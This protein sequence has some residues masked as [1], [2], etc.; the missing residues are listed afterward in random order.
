MSF[1][2]G[3]KRAYNWFISLVAAA[4]MVLY[5]YDASVFNSVQGSDNWMAYFN[6][7]NAATIGSIN[8]AYT[9]GAIFGGFFVGGPVADYLGRKV[10]M[11]TGCVLVI[12]ATFMQTFAPRHSLACFLAGR[13]I[14][15]I[16]QG[17]ALTAGP[18]YIGEL[19]PPEIRGKIMTFWQMFYSVGS[20]ICF[21]I[22]YACT[23][24]VERLGEWD[25]K[26]VVIFQLLVPILIVAL[27][28][29]M[30]G[31]PRWFI[32][33]GNNIE[34]ARSALRRV[35]ESEEE[36][37]DEILQIREAIEYEK[38]AISGNYSALWK[39]KSLR[40]RML[41]AL[42]INAGQQLTGQGSLNSYSTKIYKKVF[43]SDS[44]IALINALNATF[45]I[46]FTLNAVWIVDRFGRKFLLIVGGIGMGI[47]MIIVSAVETETPNLA[48][49][50]KSMPVG[51]STV[52][53][54]FLF[55]F[56]YKPSWGAT[57]WIWTSE[58]FSMN[59]R[60][61]AVGMASQ[62]Q[63]VANTIFQQFFPIFL[64]NDG[65]YAFYMFAGINF[66]L[67]VFV[68]FFI[69]ETKQVPL[70]EIDALFGGANHVVQGEEVLAHQKGMQI[71]SEVREVN[72]KPDAVTIENV[73]TR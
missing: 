41:L 28:P 5:G 16:G 62:T 44:Q 34:K 63:N 64:D 33:R 23:K 47:C 53:L 3:S 46:L 11:A 38:E 2:M 30:P 9:V 24:H 56:F 18:I 8:T 68:Y 6:Q 67:A 70:E 25:W 65:F 50:A 73:S 22:N 37:E 14:I 17:I 69:P 15:G 39:D 40:K 35:R 43:S 21:W 59:V 60:A 26:L 52:F 42:V 13:C 7:P 72:D 29:T 71:S 55:I 20:F 36:V 1:D 57:V 61:Q 12:A 58:V 27:L 45:G 51:I 10:G 54:L 4:C 49:G 32:K 31:S 19:A 66:L 48:D